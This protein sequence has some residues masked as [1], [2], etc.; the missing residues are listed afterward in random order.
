MDLCLSIHHILRRIISKLNLREKFAV[1]GICRQWKE[2]AIA[3]LKEHECLAI[4]EKDAS[5]F[6]PFSTCSE[7]PDSFTD[8]LISRKASDAEFWERTLSLLPGIKSVYIDVRSLEGPRYIQASDFK[9]IIRLLFNS[10]GQSLECLC[11]PGHNGREDEVEIFSPTDSLP[12]LQ[13]LF[14]SGTNEVA[15]VIKACPK[16]VQL[17]SSTGFTEWNLLPKKFKKLGSYDDDLEGIL[18]LLSSPA[19]ESLESISGILM[20]SEICYKRYRLSSLKEFS[21]VINLSLNV[22]L[23]HL[24]RILS[25]APVLQELTVEIQILDE[26]QSHSWIKVLCECQSLTKLRLLFH[27]DQEPEDPKIDVSLWQDDFASTLVSKAKNLR[28]L[29]IGFHLSSQGLRLLSQLENLEFF[30]HDLRTKNMVYDS[31]FDT[32]ALTD[33]LSSSLEK[34]LTEYNIYIPT[35]N[36]FGEYLILKESFYDFVELM[37]RKHFIQFTVEQEERHNDVSKMHP[38]KMPGMIYVTYLEVCEWGL[39]YPAIDDDDE[40]TVNLLIDLMDTQSQVH[41][42]L[43]RNPNETEIH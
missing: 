23:N 15:K 22:C 38:E 21:I 17:R 10:C 19:V 27:E 12:Q 20:S 18:N 9:A 11:I 13:H 36:P 29:F 32:D 14:L 40:E 31:V 43:L 2:N 8:N 30:H 6:W 39:I 5:T 24:A 34:K 33:F 1:Q 25:F 26:I 42:I 35:T 37:E 7:H 3:C 41:D 4:S 28:H 16:L